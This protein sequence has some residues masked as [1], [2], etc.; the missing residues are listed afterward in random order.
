M[1]NAGALRAGLDVPAGLIF[2]TPNSSTY[3][4][5]LAADAIN[6]SIINYSFDVAIEILNLPLQTYQASS[7]GTSGQRN[8]VISY[9]HPE[10]SSVGTSVYIYDSKA[11]QWL[12]IDISYPVNLSSMSF[13]VYNPVTGI[14]LN[15][16]SMTFNLL[17]NDSEY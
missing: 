13:R 3:G 6:M 5:Y 7:N 4:S 14:D 1:T 10:L 12:D 16:N 17:I 8:N 9:F 2:L 15:A 11:Y